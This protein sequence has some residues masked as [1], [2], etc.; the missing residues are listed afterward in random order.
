MQLTKLPFT[1]I[2]NYHVTCKIRNLENVEMGE[3]PEPGHESHV[4][5]TAALL[6]S[7]SLVTPW[8]QIRESG[9][10]RK[11]YHRKGNLM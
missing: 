9:M 10:S 3:L 1:G 6:T 7:H 2:G 11:S 4:I 8:V 5:H